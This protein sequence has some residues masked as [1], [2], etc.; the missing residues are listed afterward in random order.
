MRPRVEPSC[1][2]RSRSYRAVDGLL[3]GIVAGAM[4]GVIIGTTM[5]FASWNKADS[6]APLYMGLGIFGLA[7]VAGPILH[8][9][10]PEC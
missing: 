8:A 2:P 5:H 6:R 4:S 1:V 10:P 9:L 7:V 3:V